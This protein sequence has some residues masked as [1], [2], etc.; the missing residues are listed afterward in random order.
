[1]PLDPDMYCMPFHPTCLEVYKRASILHLGHV[2]IAGLASWYRFQSDY[3]TYDNFPRDAAV[4]DGHQQWW[5]HQEGNE[6]LAA[7]P[8]FMPGLPI[9]LDSSMKHDSSSLQQHDELNVVEAAIKTSSTIPTTPNPTHSDPFALLPTEI[10]HDVLGYLDPKDVA[11]LR[12]VSRN[13]LQLPTSLFRQ[14]MRDDMPWLWEVWTDLPYSRWVTTAKE[15][16]DREDEHL[17]FRKELSRCRQIISEGIPELL[18]DW[19]DAE[20]TFESVCSHHL[21]GIPALNLPPDRVDWFRLFSNIRLHWSL[22]KGLQNRHRIWKDCEEILRRIN[23]ARIDGS[24]AG[25]LDA[26]Y[27]RAGDA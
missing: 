3:D 19:R 22:L 18:I 1:M 7:N 11:N 21:R 17:Q 16:Q 26:K 23:A 14:F 2:D 10:N 8:I 4:S 6:W 25:E 15:L 24:I 12:L 27:Q 20:P 13:F 9:V 5:N